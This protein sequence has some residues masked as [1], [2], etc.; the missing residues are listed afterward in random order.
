MGAGPSKGLILVVEAYYAGVRQD[1][2]GIAFD[3]GGERKSINEEKAVAANH[4][5]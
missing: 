5:Q 4:V 2:S 1:A 3:R